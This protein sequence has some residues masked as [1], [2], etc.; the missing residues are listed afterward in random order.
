MDTV[1]Q[2]FG[3]MM[4]AVAVWML[5]RILP[6]RVTSVGLWATRWSRCRDHLLSLGE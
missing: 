2:V 5:S 1:K 6:E 3:A 4:L